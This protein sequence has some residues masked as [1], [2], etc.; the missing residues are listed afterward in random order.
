MRPGIAAYSSS[1][2]ESDWLLAG[3]S[4]QGILQRLY[5]Y[6]ENSVQRRQK[7]QKVPF[8]IQLDGRSLWISIKNISRNQRRREVRE[9]FGTR[10]IV[11]IIGIAAEEVEK[12][13]QKIGDESH[14]PRKTTWNT[15]HA[16]KLT[17]KGLWH[18]SCAMFPL[19]VGNSVLRRY[20]SNYFG[21]ELQGLFRVCQSV[22]VTLWGTVLWK[23]FV[24]FRSRWQNFFAIQ[25]ESLYNS[26]AIT[27]TMYNVLN[28]PHIRHNT[29]YQV[30]SF[31]TEKERGI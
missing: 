28:K 4:L 22:D 7:R 17:K 24:F 25:S 11:G 14:G 8:R 13:G 3:E 16:T 30:Y 31:T 29:S 23:R 10:H 27:R 6:I 15:S 18:C 12:V 26:E 2:V 9:N 21:L 19:R 1:L 20:Y 5:V